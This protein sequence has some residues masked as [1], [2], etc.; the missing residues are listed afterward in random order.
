LKVGGDWCHSVIVAAA[1]GQTNS[2]WRPR[3]KSLE[4]RFFVVGRFSDA[5]LFSSLLIHSN[6]PEAHDN[7]ILLLTSASSFKSMRALMAPKSIQF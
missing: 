1:E 5:A 3:K 6:A 4:P 2:C 7:K